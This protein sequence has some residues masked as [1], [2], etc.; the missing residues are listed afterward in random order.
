MTIM[1][2]LI[3]L[4]LALV[5]PTAFATPAV[6]FYT[7]TVFSSTYPG[8]AVGDTVSGLYVFDYAN[9]NPQNSAGTIGSAS[10]WIVAS[11]SPGTN[12][13]VFWSMAVV[14]GVTVYT[15]LGPDPSNYSYVESRQTPGI[16]IT[17]IFAT[18]SDPAVGAVG[19]FLSIMDPLT[20]INN[21]PPTYTSEGYPT[22]PLPG[23]YFV[24]IGGFQENFNPSTHF[25]VSYVLTSLIRWL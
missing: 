22:T 17:Q 2:W 6:F 4:S 21:T 19:S 5:A 16:P 18:E 24:Q 25:G 15:T 14:N 3:L 23:G 11:S 13:Y 20:F 9:A 7:G 1:K 12:P 8:V 10:P